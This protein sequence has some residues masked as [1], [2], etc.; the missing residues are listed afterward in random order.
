[1]NRFD[2]I[3]YPVIPIFWINSFHC[4]MKTVFSSYTYILCYIFFIKLTLEE[5]GKINT[6]TNFFS[7]KTKGRTFR[8][9]LLAHAGLVFRYSYTVFLFVRCFMLSCSCIVYLYFC[10]TIALLHCDR[11][12]PCIYVCILLMLLCFALIVL[13]GWH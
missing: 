12:L 4:Y 1:M 7:D 8:S 6:F 9:N 5:N 11:L 10:V 13:A 2:V 3:S